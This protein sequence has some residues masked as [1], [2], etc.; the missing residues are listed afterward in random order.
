MYEWVGD[1]WQESQGFFPELDS[2]VHRVWIIRMCDGVNSAIL[3]RQPA[4]LTDTTCFPLTKLIL[5]VAPS[6]ENGAEVCWCL[7]G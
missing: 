2:F 1:V 4:I 3:T 6:A 5:L 7:M